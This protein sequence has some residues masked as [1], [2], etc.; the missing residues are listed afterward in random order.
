MKQN[1]NLLLKRVL[2]SLV[3]IG[4]MIGGGVTL[5]Y[6]AHWT[7][8]LFPMWSFILIWIG[9]VSGLYWIFRRTLF[10]AGQTRPHPL[11]LL[12]CGCWVLAA[13]SAHSHD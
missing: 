2:Q 10:D 11:A 13:L 9:G 1:N 4:L 5:F 3:S 6:E 7:G 12:S 8:F